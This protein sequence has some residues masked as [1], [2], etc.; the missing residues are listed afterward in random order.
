[1]IIEKDKPK[2]LVLMASYNGELYIENQIESILN[3]KQVNVNVFI[4]D[5]NSCPRN[6]KYLEKITHSKKNISVKYNDKNFGS[7]GQNFFD[8]IR[9]IDVTGY[10][11]IALS[12]QDDLWEKNKIIEGIKK[13]NK[14]ELSGY[15]SAV[16]AFWPN[17]KTKKISQSSSIND[18]D[19]L[20]EGAGQGCTFILT[21]KFFKKIQTFCNENIVLTKD[22]YYHDWFIYILC[23]SLDEKWFFDK[24]T[25]IKY[26]QHSLNDTGARSG[27]KAI[28]F[29][30]K[31]INEGWYKKQVKIAIKIAKKANANSNSFNKAI[32]FYN[33]PN[34]KFRKFRLTFFILKDGR[35]KLVDKLVQIFFVLFGKL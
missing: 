12:D 35:R 25:Y 26:R 16:E 8:I 13:I 19:F 21:N 34:M 9:N 22:F 33:L 6:V 5:D 15:S 18:T 20:F 1:M 11:Y 14:L 32:K 23:R 10:E 30:V 24:N 7:A 3:Q 4:Q 17:G 31:L 27:F 29:R 2:V 28:H